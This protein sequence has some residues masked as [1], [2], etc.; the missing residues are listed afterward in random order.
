LDAWGPRLEAIDVLAGLA[1]AGAVSTQEFE[2]VFC[3]ALTREL[4]LQDAA[5]G[6]WI[7]RCLAELVSARVLSPLSVS[8]IST[9]CEAAG[10]GEEVI[11]VLERSKKLWKAKK[12]FAAGLR[13][14]QRHATRGAVQVQQEIS[15]QGLQVVMRLI[16]SHKDSHR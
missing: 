9:A 4:Q 2:C 11:S 8:T 1:N 15:N 16:W 5:H 6:E 13:R 14:A 10:S 7:A 3:H 12:T